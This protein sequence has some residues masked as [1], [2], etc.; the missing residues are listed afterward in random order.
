ME[1]RLVR[2]PRT[3]ALPRGSPSQVLRWWGWFHVVSG[4]SFWLMVLPGEARLAQPWWTPARRILRGWK[5]TWLSFWPLLNSSTWWWFVSFVFLTRTSCHSI[6]CAWLL[7]CLARVGGF[8]QVSLNNWAWYAAFVAFQKN[9]ASLETQQ[10]LNVLPT[11]CYSIFI[12]LDCSKID[13]K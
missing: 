1:R 10:M 9:E 5:D 11:E 2:E 12:L 6:A 7:W 4:L 8:H 13:K 3:T